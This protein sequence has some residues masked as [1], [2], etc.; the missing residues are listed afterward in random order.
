MATREEVEMLV[1]RIRK[2]NDR[3]L[4]DCT[5]SEEAILEE[6]LKNGCLKNVIRKVVGHRLA[7]LS[8]KP[9]DDSEYEAYSIDTIKINEIYK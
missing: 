8:F 7:D 5:N 9:S 1:S 4:I 3:K 6:L 2:N